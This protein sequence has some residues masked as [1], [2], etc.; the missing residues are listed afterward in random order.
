MT[1]HACGYSILDGS[2]K[3]LRC[4][5]NYGEVMRAVQEERA[6]TNDDSNEEF[7]EISADDV[8][9]GRGTRGGGFPC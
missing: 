2:F 1:C 6:E 3:C 8:Y 7:I 9:M 4:G 5:A